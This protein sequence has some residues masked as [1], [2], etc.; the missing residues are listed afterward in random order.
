MYILCSEHCFIYY[1][2]SEL[3]HWSISMLLLQTWD[4]QQIELY[5]KFKAQLL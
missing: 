3:C 4:S 1:Q 5:D 2:K